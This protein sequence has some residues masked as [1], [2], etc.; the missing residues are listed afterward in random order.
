MK[1][2][3]DDCGYHSEDERFDIVKS[4]DRIHNGDWELTDN[5]TKK[6]QHGYSLKHAKQIAES[7]EI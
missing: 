4:T 1:W 2:I 6:K 3:K 7:V 5:K